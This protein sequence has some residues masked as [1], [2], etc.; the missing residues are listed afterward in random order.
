MAMFRNVMVYLGLG[1]DD[2]YDENYL[3][4]DEN[5]DFEGLERRTGGHRASD[6]VRIVEGDDDLGVGA[7]RP[8][9]PVPDGAGGERPFSDLR[10]GVS[11]AGFDSDTRPSATEHPS[12]GLMNEAADSGPVGE[13]KPE[14]FES[15]SFGLNTDPNS[16]KPDNESGRSSQSNPASQ[17]GT[18]RPGGSFNGQPS[19]STPS[20]AGSQPRTQNER[21]NFPM[22]DFSQNQ[23]AR[24][25]KPRSVVPR[26]FDDAK[27]VA[28]EYQ[29]GAPVVM[30]LRETDKETGRRLLDFSSGMVY[31]LGGGMEKLAANVF[32]ITPD[33]VEVSAEDR[34]RLEERGYGR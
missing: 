18:S 7:V 24:G 2:E 4:D 22:D 25:A 10:P 6:G 28:N 32:L 11:A 12:G 23:G 16:A 26:S 3:Y 33:G 8:L 13:R 14:P 29:A 19:D 15:G 20:Q 34:R 30:N 27:N 1:P 5:V 31:G 9:R 17:P 21:S